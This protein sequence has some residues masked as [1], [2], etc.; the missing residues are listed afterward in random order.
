MTGTSVWTSSSGR[1]WPTWHVR[2]RRARSCWTLRRGGGGVCGEQ[3]AGPKLC[4][5]DRPPGQNDTMIII[6]LRP[7]KRDVPAVR[8]VTVH[9]MCSPDDANDSPTNL[10]MLLFGVGW[11]TKNSSY[12][13]CAASF[14][15]T[16]PNQTWLSTLTM[17]THTNTYTHTMI[18]FV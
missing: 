18:N 8:E 3:S 14:C 15:Y 4:A 10:G 16:R 17:Y 2:S 6:Y 7:S 11:N 13:R 12:Y 9:A 5:T 1:V